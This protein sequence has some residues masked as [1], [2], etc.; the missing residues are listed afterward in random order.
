MIFLNRTLATTAVA[1]AAVLGVMPLA[2]ADTV[3][4]SPQLTAFT[5]GSAASC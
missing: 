5:P 2:H 3:A 1:A 4:W